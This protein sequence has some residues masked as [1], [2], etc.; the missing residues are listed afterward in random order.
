MARQ[1]KKKVFVND[2]D[3]AIDL[4]RSV[5][6]IAEEKAQTKIKMHHSKASAGANIGHQRPIA[7]KSRERLERA[8]AAVAAQAARAKREKA[9]ERKK[10]HMPPGP[11][12]QTQPGDATQT[13]S[14]GRP[15]DDS[16]KP[17]KRVTFG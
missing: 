3:A 14:G 7:S 16:A 9:K 10:A 5:S 12:R 13:E 2:K 11:S 15:P 8:K 17:R 1:G 4:A 6:D